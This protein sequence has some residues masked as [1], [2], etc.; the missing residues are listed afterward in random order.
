MD[1]LV[2]VLI[3]EPPILGPISIEGPYRNDGILPNLGLF[4]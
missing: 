1:A 3:Y 2:W 4:L